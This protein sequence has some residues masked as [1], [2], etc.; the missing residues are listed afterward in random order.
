MDMSVSSR[1][2][3]RWY[4]RHG[5]DL[6][7]RNTHNPYKILVSEM[8]LQQTQV[9]RVV[10]FYRRWL[11]QFPNWNS[12]A[13][14][15]NA[16]VI[17]AWAGLGYNRRALMLRDIA[18][19]IVQNSVPS[20][21]EEWR[22]LKGIGTYT[23]AAI[24]VFAFGERT[25]P[26]D[27]NVRR[28]LGRLFLGVPY[29]QPKLDARIRS[30]VES[31]LPKQKFEDVPQALFDLATDLCKKIPDCARCPLRSECKA[32]HK[33][34]SGRVRVPKQMVK[35]PLERRHRNKPYPDRIY[36]GRILKLVREQTDVKIK[37]IGSKI[38]ETFDRQLDALWVQ[39]MIERLIKEEFLKKRNRG[40]VA[41]VSLFAPHH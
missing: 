38:D 33:F 18:K 27:T 14:A 7:W 41:S 16:E 24:R 29:P 13:Q 1:K 25:I 31:F 17:H 2:L 34:L 12:L 8:M 40:A 3:M 20:S 21:Q 4:D 30:H 6:P 36:R 35:K 37:D 5:R 23:A 9:D 32:A 11:K 19:H 22:S 15:T 26:I 28:V 10:L 39:A